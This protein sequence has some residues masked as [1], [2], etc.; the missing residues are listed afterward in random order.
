MAGV[1]KDGKNN[2]AIHLPSN[3]ESEK[4]CRSDLFILIRLGNVVRLKNIAKL[5]RRYE[6]PD[7]LIKQ[8]GKNHPA[9]ARDAKPGNNIV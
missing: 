1:L 7:S 3:F 5:K 4:D 2:L 8:T 9:F 6:E